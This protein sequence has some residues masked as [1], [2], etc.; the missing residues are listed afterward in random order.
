M[1][2]PV[3]DTRL[4]T[5]LI[6]A[7]MAAENTEG[8]FYLINENGFVVVFTNASSKEKKSNKGKS[9][10]K[11]LRLDSWLFK[12]SGIFYFMRMKMKE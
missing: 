3:L 10:G 8:D 2:S 6:A 5:R 9:I 11:L 1:F 7:F 12:N 4:K